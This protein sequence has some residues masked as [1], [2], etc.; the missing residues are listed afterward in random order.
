MITPNRGALMLVWLAFSGCIFAE[1]HPVNT[2]IQKVLVNHPDVVAAQAQKEALLKIVHQVQTGPNPELELGF[3]QKN[4]GISTGP[5]FET[6]LKQTIVYPGK[7][8]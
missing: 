8:E 6:I 2:L 7:T 4:D 1:A 5:A 3:G